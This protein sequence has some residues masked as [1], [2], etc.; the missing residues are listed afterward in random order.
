MRTAIGLLHLPVVLV[1]AA[2]C[3]CTV[4]RPVEIVDQTRPTKDLGKIRIVGHA[5]GESCQHFVLGIPVTPDPP[6]NDAYVEAIRK[7]TA[8]SLINVAADQVDF[9]IGLYGNSCVTVRGDGVVRK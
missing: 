3:G 7:S 5:T 9:S 1:T 8:S 2:L 6:L 4:Y